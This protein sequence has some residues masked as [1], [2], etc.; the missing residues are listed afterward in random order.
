MR[1][2]SHARS[3]LDNARNAGGI[4]AVCFQPLREREQVWAGTK[5]M[6]QLRDFEPF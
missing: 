6:P 3:V 2:L 1:S 4:D 5:V